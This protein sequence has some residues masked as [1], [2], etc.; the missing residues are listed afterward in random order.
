[1]RKTITSILILSFLITP[2]LSY[3]EVSTEGAPRATIVSENTSSQTQSQ[4]SGSS[5][6]DI[7]STVG[8]NVAGCGA[9]QILSGLI[10]S[11]VS[12]AVG[13]TVDKLTDALTNVPV[14]ESGSVG[15]NIKTEVNARVGMS[16]GAFGITGLAAPSWDAVAYCIVNAMIIY[17]ADSTIEWINT[18]FNGNPAFLNNPDLFFKQLADEEAGAFIQELAYGVTG[19]N[20]CDVFR[21]SIV[22]SAVNKYNQQ[23][24]YSYGYDNNGYGQRG[25]SNGF[26]GC[27]FDDGTQMLDRFVKGDFIQGGGWNSWYNLS[28][29]PNNNPY[30]V[31]FNVNDQLT[32]AINYVL[33]S[34]NRELNWNN[35][36]LNYTKCTNPKDKSTCKTVTPGSVIQTQLNKTLNLSTDR[37]VLADKFDQVVTALV[38][39]LIT[40]ALGKALETVRE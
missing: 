33:S 6:R 7:A 31:Y 40:T 5:N 23:N 18:G 8:T 10:V 27:G 30:D 15:A 21:A 1:M 22:L 25:L 9:A 4:S 38:N 2:V 24:Q 26:L 32:N 17:I 11:S 3:A 14:A 13:K 35:G 28:Q 20:I 34:K 19:K 37:L 12:S 36:F 16:V 39:K 29:N